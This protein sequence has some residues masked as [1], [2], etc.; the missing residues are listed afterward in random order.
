M[1]STR[2]PAADGSDIEAQIQT[3]RDDISTLTK[4]LRD[5]ADN[6]F[7]EARETARA[8]AEDVLKRTRQAAG[9]ASEKAKDSVESIEAYIAQKPVQSTL[10]AL[11]VGIFIGS[12]TRR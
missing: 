11:L 4:L 10:I 6:K 8:E 2:K 1:A 9:E 3:I 7:S 5:V 12:V